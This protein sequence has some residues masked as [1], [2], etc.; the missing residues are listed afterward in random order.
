MKKRIL[1]T[2]LCAILFLL[3]ACGT[4]TPSPTLKS[5]QKP[6]VSAKPTSVAQPKMAF[7]DLP[8]LDGSTANLPLAYALVSKVCGL[9]KDDAKAK[10][11]FS[12]TTQCYQKLM[13]NK[14]DLVLAYE[15]K[16]DIMKKVKE[17]CTLSPIGIDGLVFITSSKNPVN[18]L[19][20]QQVIDIYTGKITNWKQVGGN[21]LPIFPFQ[22]DPASGSQVMFVKLAMKG[23]QPMNPARDNV[24]SSMEGL[25]SGVAAEYDNS[26]GA[27]GFS[28]YYYIHDM[29]KNPEL[30]VLKID[31]VMP[32][33]DSLAKRQYAYINPFFVAV[34]KDVS[35]NTKIIYDWLMSFGGSALLS[36]A[37]Y[38]PEH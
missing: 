26:H 3:T 6:A 25:T 10:I 35:G 18:S 27:L 14:T 36:E 8:R 38:V 9:T 1:I 20:Q 33:A 7:K 34:R 19:T 28:V 22:R 15:G 11:K 32:S 16:E 37:G 17:S 29:I 21:D 2:S 5:S 13:E 31:G 4:S 12:T 24:V 23:K 30:K